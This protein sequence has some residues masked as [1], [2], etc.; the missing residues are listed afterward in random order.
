MFEGTQGLLEP[1]PLLHHQACNLG[2]QTQQGSQPVWGA[3]PNVLNPAGH[4]HSTQLFTSS[5]QNSFTHTQLTVYVPLFACAPLPPLATAGRPYNS[6]SQ[7]ENL[8]I[9]ANNKKAEN[10]FRIICQGMPSLSL[11]TWTKRG[12]GQ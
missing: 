8:T 4:E 11:Y 2:A 12:P 6:P 1:N 7:F 5:L 9:R 10:S 3:A